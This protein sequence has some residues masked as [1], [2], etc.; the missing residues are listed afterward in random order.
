MA[1]QHD[2]PARGPK[3][4]EGPLFVAVN[5]RMRSDGELLSRNN[6]NCT[7]GK[8]WI[9]WKDILMVNE[10]FQVV[11]MPFINGVYKK[12]SE[13]IHEV[14]RLA[15]Y[16]YYFVPDEEKP[17]LD[18]LQEK[19]A[20]PKFKNWNVEGF[21]QDNRENY[22]PDNVEWYIPSR[23]ERID[24]LEKLVKMVAPKVKSYKGFVIQGIDVYLVNKDTAAKK[25]V[26]QQLT[27]ATPPKGDGKPSD[28][29]N[30]GID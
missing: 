20:C 10:K 18:E 9:Q 28:D 12:K 27:I 25:T 11:P 5:M 1:A 4:C 24:D 29:D 16:A 19:G 23:K 3:Q 14:N 13:G 30:G 7:E 15:M 8:E 2:Q 22:R 17:T 26:H 6:R 21:Q